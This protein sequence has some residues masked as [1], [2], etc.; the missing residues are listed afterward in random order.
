APAADHEQ[1][2]RLREATAMLAVSRWMY[3]SALERTESRGMHRRSDY[4]GTDVTQHHRVI[5][6]GL[7]DVW[8]GHERLGPVMEQLL[9]GQ[10]A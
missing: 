6:G 4:A 2:L 7:D 1:T 5:S 3:R 8:T 9:R 10:A